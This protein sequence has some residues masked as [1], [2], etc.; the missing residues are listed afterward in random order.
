MKGGIGAARLATTATLF[1]LVL[2][3]QGAWGVGV[4]GEATFTS[5]EDFDAGTHGDT[6][7]SAGD[8]GLLPPFVD[9]FDGT[10]LSEAW[11]VDLHT[12]TVTVSGGS[13]TLRGGTYFPRIQTRDAVL[14][15]SHAFRVEVDYQYLR[16]TANGDGLGVGRFFLWQDFALGGTL[17]SIGCAS[18]VRAA[19]LQPHHLAYAYDGVGNYSL[20][21]DGGAL[22]AC[23]GQPPGANGR[24]FWI[25]NLDECCP[26]VVYNDIRVDRVAALPLGGS[27]ASPVV[28]LSTL[29]AAGV[30]VPVLAGEAIG[31]ASWD[32]SVPSGASVA[33][34]L[35]SSR[36]GGATWGSWRQVPNG[37]PQPLALL[38]PESQ[39]ATH[40][41]L[42]VD[43]ATDDP[44]GAAPSLHALEFR[45]V[46]DLRL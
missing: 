11:S 2:A 42:R 39:L 40:A 27:W 33:V 16:F 18:V 34:W 43:L 25:G 13:V 29:A 38:A 6:R 24:Q 41:Q 12:G 20:Q 4:L 30:A 37:D 19:H 32:A 22:L 45:W 9:D 17:Y 26:N 23:G 46:P 14:P 36:D 8:L 3:G 5:D 21:L 44:I 31:S 28:E 15:A 7:A 35:R 1:G 10:A